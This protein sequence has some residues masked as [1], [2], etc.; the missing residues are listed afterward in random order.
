MRKSSIDRRSSLDNED[1]FDVKRLNCAAH[2]NLVEG[3]V[4]RILFT[5]PVWIFAQPDVEKRTKA[6][7]AIVNSK[8][9]ENLFEHYSIW[10]CTK[11]GSISEIFFGHGL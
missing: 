7:E 1:Q 9:V 11:S 8:W 2:G 4:K 10:G 5:D 6:I 3:E